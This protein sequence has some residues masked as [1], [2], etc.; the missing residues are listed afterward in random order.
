V[1]SKLQRATTVHLALKRLGYLVL[2]QSFFSLYGIFKKVFVSVEKKRYKENYEVLEYEKP[3]CSL[4]LSSLKT[5]TATPCGHVF[6]WDCI[7]TAAENNPMCPNCRQKFV[8]QSLLQL[9]N[10]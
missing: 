5:P 10:Y 6:C 2:V 8:P 3:E 1:L 9:R 4:C 7:F